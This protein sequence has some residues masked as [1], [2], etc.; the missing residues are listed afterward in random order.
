MVVNNYCFILIGNPWWVAALAVIGSLLLI[1]IVAG[2]AAVIC[3]CVNNRDGNSKGMQSFG[4]QISFAYLK[5]YV[6]GLGFKFD[7]F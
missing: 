4:I 2:V 3:Y 6:S 7:K 1:I 5:C